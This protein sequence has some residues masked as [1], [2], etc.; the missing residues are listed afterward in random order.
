MN[1]RDEIQNRIL[2]GEGAMG[3]LLY[4]TGVD[5]CYE[6]LNIINPD[7]VR[8]VHQAYVHAGS[9]ILQSNTYGANH[10]KLKRYGLEDKVSSINREGM[11]IAK[12]AALEHNFVFGTIG[13]TR[14]LRKSDITL[15][16][17]KRNF[18]EQLFS[19][20]LENPDGLI[21]ETFYDFEEMETVLKIARQETPLPIIANISLHEIGY[22]Q[23]GMHLSEALPILEDMGADA[24]GVNCRLGPHHTIR[25]LEQVPVPSKSVLS[26]Y[27]NASLPEYID[28][29]LQYETNAEYFGKS[30]LLL[31][32]QGVRIIGGCCGTTP[33]HIE[34]VKKNLNGLPPIFEKNVSPRKIEVNE[35]AQQENEEALYK[36]VEHKR[37][38]LVELDPPKKLD[39]SAYLEGTKALIEAGADTITMAD[40]SLASPRISNMAMGS[41][42]KQQG[43]NP[44]VHL[45]CRDHNLIG[46]Q[47]HLMGLHTLGLDEILVITGDP[48]KVGDFPGATSVYDVSSM[49]LISLV[50]QY[51]DGLS[52]SG[53]PLG[54]KT[55]FKVAAAFNPNVKY[56]HK[57]VGRMERKIKAG[58]DSFLTQPIYSVNQ[59]EEIY[60][61]TKHI[62][63]PIFMGIMPLT[64]YRNAEY[65][66]H[67]VP[68]ITLPDS[69]LRAM[70][71]A[72]N[73]R[74]QAE[75][76]GLAIA[77][78][79][80]QATMERFKGIYLITPFLRYNITVE[81]TKFVRE[82]DAKQKEEVIVYE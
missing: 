37:T 11:R 23:N 77:K 74:V 79:L 38:I 80:V 6:E 1:F 49:D 65:I 35:T 55:N 67:E 78:E 66:H 20:L 32:E 54:Q 43:V 44:L 15:E 27:P 71:K 56:L 42:L 82:I 51:N 30:A 25:S 24:V 10:Y 39:I 61:A 31:R 47:S 45:T 57:A 72:G 33:S 16:E 41:I 64:S 75:R 69:V 4:S 70:E 12:S 9:D 58:A 60:Q 3:T 2:I 14:S 68:G 81:L 59:V 21:L 36:K 19:L 63:A 5:Q 13:A 8:S 22:L 48:S 46:L 73:D 52:Y 76:E 29:R 18:R 26:A 17:I 40:N 28:G 50:K 53:K 7:L 34:E 62:T